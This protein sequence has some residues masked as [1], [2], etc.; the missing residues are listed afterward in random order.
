MR[1]WRVTA[2]GLVPNEFC[3]RNVCGCRYVLSTRKWMI[4]AMPPSCSLYKEQEFTPPFSW[5]VG[6]K[7]KWGSLAELTSQ[8]NRLT[9]IV[10]GRNNG[11]CM[12]YTCIKHKWQIH[13][14][15]IPP[16]VC[17]HIWQTIRL[18]SCL[19]PMLATVSPTKHNHCLGESYL[20]HAAISWPM[21]ELT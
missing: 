1:V 11:A 9:Q 6:G 15:R 16:N 8:L 4:R 10:D 19:F 5:R 13:Q 7:K 20:Q 21:N 12:L 18:T 3:N 14:R 17:N 2:V